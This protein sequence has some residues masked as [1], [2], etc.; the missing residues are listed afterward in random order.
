VATKQ[1]D[2]P[3]YRKLP[4]AGVSP[5]MNTEDAPLSVDEAMRRFQDAV[6]DAR[7]AQL[8]WIESIGPPPGWKKIGPDDLKASPVDSEAKEGNTKPMTESTDYRHELDLRDEQLRRELDLRH[9]SSRTE[10]AERDK[11]WNERFSG[12]LAQQVERDKRL[13][14]SIASIAKSQDETKSGITSMKT[15]MIVTAVST[16]LAIVIGVASF[17]AT[18]TSNMFSAFQAGKA[19]PA[20]QPK[21][22][23]ADPAKTEPVPAASTK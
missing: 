10:Q 20:V 12:F 3:T 7:R 6:T 17:N 19:E 16:V 2:D 14:A 1:M 23:P 8:A 9:E 11:A 4:E 5:S 22:A 18:L 13:D 15:T 21:A